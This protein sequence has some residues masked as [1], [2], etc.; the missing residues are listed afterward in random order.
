M[1]KLKSTSRL[2]LILWLFGASIADSILLQDV[3][4][5]QLLFFLSQR[6]NF[7]FRLWLGADLG[8]GRVE[9]DVSNSV[10]VMV[11]RILTLIYFVLHRGQL[12]LHGGH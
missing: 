10:F 4:L 12:S 3:L 6:I 8:F 1:F 9:N 2:F 5:S 7:F 11:E